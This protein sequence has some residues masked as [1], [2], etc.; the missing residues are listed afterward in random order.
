MAVKMRLKR[1]GKKKQPL[2]RIVVA[3]SRMPRDG[4]NIDEI[5]FYNPKTEPSTIEIDED[6]A[7]MWLERGAQ[8]SGT[9]RKLLDITGAWNRF[10]S[11]KKQREEE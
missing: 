10:Q 9:V 3:D 1:I 2:Y 8:P 6:R 4:R 11:S 5:G 7:V